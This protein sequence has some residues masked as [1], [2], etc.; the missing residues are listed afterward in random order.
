[1]AAGS[2]DSRR[3]RMSEQCPIWSV[4]TS[5][6]TSQTVYRCV[7]NVGH[8][9]LHMDYLGRPFAAQPAS[10]DRQGAVREALQLLYDETADY[11]R[12][13]HLGDVHHN[14]SMQLARDA[15]AAQ[16]VHSLQG[17]A[18]GSVT[19]S[20]RVSWKVVLSFIATTPG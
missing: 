2:G 8:N 9:G 7:S 15:L 17:A 11:I 5:D 3:W 16:P 12:I 1:P 18:A 14:R 20:E 6:K 19:E 4:P 13:N 10:R